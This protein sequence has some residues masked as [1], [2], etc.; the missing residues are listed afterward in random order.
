MSNNFILIHSPS[1]IKTINT[2]FVQGNWTLIFT[3]H[4]SNHKKDFFKLSI[5]HDG[6]PSILR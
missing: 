2:K 3:K 6:G 5:S 4:D 1:T